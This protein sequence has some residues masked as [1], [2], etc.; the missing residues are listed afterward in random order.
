[1]DFLVAFP[2]VLVHNH[3]LA[4]D[5]S[6]IPTQTINGLISAGDGSFDILLV[7]VLG[8]R[9]REF[10][11]DDNL[12]FRFKIFEVVE[13]VTNLMENEVVGLIP[14]GLLGGF[15]PRDGR[16]FNGRKIL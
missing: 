4:P 13:F 3:L 5:Q 6:Q 14:K 11:K 1:M 7:A 15:G 12:F 8:L 10:I 2:L 16:L 9:D